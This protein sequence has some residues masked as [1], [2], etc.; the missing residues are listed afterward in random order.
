MDETGGSSFENCLLLVLIALAILAALTNLGQTNSHIF[1]NCATSTM[2]GS[3][4]SP[5][6]KGT[7]PLLHE[8]GSWMKTAPVPW[9][10]AC[11]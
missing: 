3:V 5:G 8:R 6:N 7:R 10:I 1:V 11:C 4:G 9:S 2:R